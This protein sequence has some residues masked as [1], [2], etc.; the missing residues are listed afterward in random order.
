M[1]NCNIPPD[2]ML[3]ESPLQPDKYP[4][5]IFSTEPPDEAGGWSN[6]RGARAVELLAADD[7]VTAEE[8]ISFAMDRKSYGAGR[9]IEALQQSHDAY[10]ARISGN[11]DAYR[12][13]LEDFLQWDQEL[14]SGSTGALKY[15]YWREEIANSPNPDLKG[16]SQ[17]INNYRES[18]T[19]ESKPVKLTR[20]ELQALA[21][22]FDQAMQRLVKDF[23][24]IHITYGQV[25][26]VGRGTQSWPLG[27]GGRF[28]LS[29]LRN[30]NHGAPR[31]DKT[32]WGTS[33]QTSTQVVIMSQP[34]RSWTVTPLGQSD[35]PESPHYSDQAEKLFS[36]ASMKPSWWLPEQLK[37]HIESRTELD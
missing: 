32:R 3:V 14:N 12:E 29:T 19:G 9:W 10:G 4:S 7:S 33:G 17:K 34:V 2:S 36:K 11:S 25:F 15:A 23:G 5:Y 22:S 26:R 1:Q 13:G 31:E 30:V 27:G 21:E 24:E 8:A 37:D 18:V 16:I 28:G 20:K 35:R 6:P